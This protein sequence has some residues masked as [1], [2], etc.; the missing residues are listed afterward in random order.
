MRKDVKYK[1]LRIGPYLFTIKMTATNDELLGKGVY[2]DI[3]EHHFP[4][5][6]WFG[7]F[8][9]WWKLTYYGHGYWNPNCCD[10]TLEQRLVWKCDSIVK[11]MDNEKSFQKQWENI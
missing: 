7:R 2:Y 5:R 6:T 8:C 3:Y 11:Q 4:A 9:Q 10:D 1:N